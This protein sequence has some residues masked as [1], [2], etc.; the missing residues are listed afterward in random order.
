MLATTTTSNDDD[1]YYYFHY[2]YY[3][4]VLLS[5]PLSSPKIK[6]AILGRSSL[7]IGGNGGDHP[8]SRASRGCILPPQ[9]GAMGLLTIKWSSLSSR[10]LR[11]GL[12]CLVDPRSGI[13]GP[14]AP[15]GGYSHERLAKAPRPP[16]Y[17]LGFFLLPRVVGDLRMVVFEGWSLPRKSEESI[18][19]GRNRKVVDSRNL[20]K[21]S[22]VV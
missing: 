11:G 15:K 3:T 12:G 8:P 22:V 16:P 1:D 14:M 5:L 20:E 10:F 18:E 7:R 9:Q 21:K 4:I 13:P 19:I 2:Y 6:G 17:N